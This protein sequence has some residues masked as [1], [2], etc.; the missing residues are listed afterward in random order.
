MM[1]DYDTVFYIGA[2]YH[3]YERIYPYIKGGD[4]KLIP[5]PYNLTRSTKDLISIVEGIAGNDKS[6]VET[7]GSFL[8]SRQLY[9][10]MWRD[11]VSWNAN[12]KL[13]TYDHYKAT[14]WDKPIDSVSIQFDQ[15]LKKSRIYLR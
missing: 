8:T 2:H 10:I 12:E 14:Q 9:L 15:L 7:Y 6:I 13:L 3:T 4:F 1:V 11:T 5:G